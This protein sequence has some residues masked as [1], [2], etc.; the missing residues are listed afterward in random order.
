MNITVIPMEETHL[1]AVAE[2]EK[3][4]F[5]LPWSLNLLRESMEKSLFWVALDEN[6]TLLGYVSLTPVL[7]EGHINNVATSPHLRNQGIATLLLTELLRFAKNHLNLL[8]L[9]VRESNLHAIKL[10]ENFHFQII[11]TRKNYYSSP[12]ENALIMTREF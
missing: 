1:K 4:C 5:T 11:A 3:L 8:L 2:L 12:T 10:Y 6:D 7:D 9:E